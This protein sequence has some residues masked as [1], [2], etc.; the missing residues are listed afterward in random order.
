[1]ISFQLH[2]CPWGSAALPIGCYRLRRLGY[3]MLCVRRMAA[4][5]ASSAS[6]ASA[7][8]AVARTGASAGAWASSAA[9]SAGISTRVEKDTMGEV[10]V[11][12]DRYWGAQ[13]Q[14]SIN[15]FP[16]GGIESRMPAQVWRSFG[17]AKKAAAKVN[18]RMGKMPEDLGGKIVEAAD[19]VIS[20]K[21]DD[22]FPLVVFQTG[23]GTQ[24]NMNVN[25]VIANRAIEMLGGELGSQTPVHPNDHVNMGMSSN[26]SFPTA[27]HIAAALEIAN[28]TIPGLEK[29]HAALEA[30][31]SEFAS[32]VK[33]GRTHTQD[34][35]PLTLGQEFSGYS[36]QIKNG[37][38]RAKGVLP[39]LLELA[40]GGT[41]VGTGLN[42]IEGFDAEFAA[43]VAAETGLPFVTAPNKFEALAAHDAIVEASG[44]CR[45]TAHT[46]LRQCFPV[47]LV[48]VVSAPLGLVQDCKPTPPRAFS[49]FRS[50]LPPS[51][52]RAQCPLLRRRS[53]RLGVQP[54]QDRQ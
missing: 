51:L 45:K 17:I 5:A 40:M 33:I 29:L 31:S 36:M 16:I 24:T 10:E 37:I 52:L 25:E 26:D 46:G 9:A 28:T 8:A 20:G 39:A 2:L 48:F 22:H 43:E 6:T 19:E 11:P 38:R 53:Q 41:A 50:S 15:N 54:E 3:D 12:T 23:S 4:V 27:M 30:K 13:T 21:L 44:E 32:I 49:A 1:M 34:A 35:T 7:R 47:S 18:M 42:S 14:R